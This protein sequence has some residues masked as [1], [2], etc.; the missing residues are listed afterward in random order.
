MGSVISDTDY[1]IGVKQGEYVCITDGWAT[2]PPKEAGWYWV[3]ELK[4][5]EIII[6]RLDDDYTVLAWGDDYWCD[7]DIR[8]ITHWLGPLP[9]P[10]PPQE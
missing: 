3:K 6:A 4:G 9:M 5:D 2:E 7:V 10:E 8:Q 1:V